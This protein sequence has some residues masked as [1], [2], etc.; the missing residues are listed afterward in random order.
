MY[1]YVRITPHGRG[2]M[3]SRSKYK[4]NSWR[5][6]SAHPTPVSSAATRSGA[7]ALS[8]ER[9]HTCSL[10]TSDS[11]AMPENF[12]LTFCPIPICP[13]CGSGRP[14]PV[15]LSSLTR[16]SVVTVKWTLVE[17]RI[18]RSQSQAPWYAPRHYTHSDSTQLHLAH[19]APSLSTAGHERVGV[20]IHF[21]N[22][23]FGYNG[24]WMMETHDSALFPAATYIYR[25]KLQTFARQFKIS[26]LLILT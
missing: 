26:F 3:I 19:T 13:G 10:H 24:C 22:D 11:E 2:F 5:R 18:S 20:V 6:L 1:E 17:H 12:P 8:H 21:I 14:E 4:Y 23:L 9:T 16:R 7:L 25:Q 15:S